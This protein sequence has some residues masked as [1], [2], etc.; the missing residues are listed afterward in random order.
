EPF[1]WALD[2][3][4]GGVETSV[5]AAHGRTAVV[6]VGNDPHLHGRE[7]E[8]RPHVSLPAP[9]VALIEAVAAVAERTVLVV[10]SSYPYA[11]GAVA[12]LVDAVVWTSHAGQ[13][14]GRAI[15]D[16]LTGAAEPHGRLTQAWPASDADVHDLLDYDVIGSRQTYLYAQARAA[17]PFGHGLHYSSTGLADASSSVSEVAAGPVADPSADA[18]TISVSVANT[19]ARDVS[20]VVQVYVGVDEQ[21]TPATTGPRRPFPRRRLVSWSRVVVAA[22]DVA[23]V[24]LAVPLD[25]FAQWDPRTQAW[26]VEPG[27]YRVHVGTSAEDLAASFPVT[28]AGTP[29]AAVA[30]GAE[31]PVALYDDGTGVELWTSPESLATSVRARAGGR[32]TL[33]FLDVTVGAAR[34]LE[35]VAS[36]GQGVVSFRAAAAAGRAAAGELVVS[37]AGGATSSTLDGLVAGE[38]VDLELAFGAGLELSAFR[39]V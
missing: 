25:A 37:G 23:T 28:A 7:T 16:V 5:A 35:L 14:I 9:S 22:G 39:L 13:E 30:A 36:S 21:A 29:I 31:F 27:A 10:V 18:G 26:V 4:A 38:P 34:Q 3:V 15:A 2:V 32:V 8:D 24:S 17:F 11:L 6:V 33:R 12:D 20:E 19:G 1:D